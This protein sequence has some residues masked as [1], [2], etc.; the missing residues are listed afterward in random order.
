MPEYNEGPETK[1]KFEQTMRTLFQA[2]R[3]K[4]PNEKPAATLRKPTHSD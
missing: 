4:K 2:P 1:E 3:P